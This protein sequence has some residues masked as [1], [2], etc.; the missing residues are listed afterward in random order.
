MKKL[1]VA[2]LHNC[3]D[4]V[5]HFVLFLFAC[6]AILL[7]GCAQEHDP[8]TTQSGVSGSASANATP[9]FASTV[10]Y[11]ATVTPAATETPAPTPT[12]TP[13]APALID[14]AQHA[15]FLGD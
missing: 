1:R 11:A 13:D 15:T 2:Q 3:R 5:R 14:Q 7:V 8:A 6:T 4:A 9:T 10:Q 12:S